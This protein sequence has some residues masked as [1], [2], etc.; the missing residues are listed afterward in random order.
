MAPRNHFDQPEAVFQHMHDSRLS[1]S[2]DRAEMPSRTDRVCLSSSELQFAP[3]SFIVGGTFISVVPQFVS[4]QRFWS[5]IQILRIIRAGA[6]QNI[7][8]KLLMEE[9][10]FADSFLI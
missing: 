6:Y 4:S 8:A 1:R 2:R 9:I 10:T 3:C 7:H 5:E